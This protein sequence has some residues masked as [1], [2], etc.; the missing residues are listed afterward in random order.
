MSGLLRQ[1]ADAFLGFSKTA[2]YEGPNAEVKDYYGEDGNGRHI[3]R[4]VMT[5][6]PTSMVAR[7]P[8]QSG[9]IPGDHRNR[10]GERWDEFLADISA[11]GIQSPIFIIEDWDQNP[12]IS[13]GN[14]RR[15]AAVELG[16]PEVPVQIRYF[17]NAQN[18]G[19]VFERASY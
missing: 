1:R 13:E 2:D 3:T 17:G 6:L 9:E 12:V 19:S 16:M 14:H 4:D 7:M 10:K 18:Q 11:N 15:D 8:G 5:T